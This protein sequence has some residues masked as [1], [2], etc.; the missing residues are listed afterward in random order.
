MDL[1]KHINEARKQPIPNEALIS[2]RKSNFN[3]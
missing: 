1:K 2:Y 3:L